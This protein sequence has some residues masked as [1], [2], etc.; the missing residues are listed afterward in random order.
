MKKDRTI[1]LPIVWR[2]GLVFYIKIHSTVITTRNWSEHFA[3]KSIKAK[4]CKNPMTYANKYIRQRSTVVYDKERTLSGP[5]GTWFVT[6][7]NFLETLIPVDC[8]NVWE[9]YWTQSRDAD[10]A[11]LTNKPISRT[12]ILHSLNMKGT[13]RITLKLHTDISSKICCRGTG[14]NYFLK[15]KKECSVRKY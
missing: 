2:W 15:V 10:C 11:R 7:C 3:V 8:P 6:M 5:V 9:L 12:F 14:W 13:K 4:A 1:S